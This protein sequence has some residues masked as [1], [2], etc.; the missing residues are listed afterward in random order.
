MREH[1]RK[2]SAVSILLGMD[3][4]GSSESIVRDWT[5]WLLGKAFGRWLVGIVGLAIMATGIGVGVAGFRAEFKDQ[6]AL[7]PKP[8]LLVTAL[9]IAG[10]LARSL[11]TTTIGLFL[12][13]A[14]I[15]ASARE[16]KGFAGAL[17]VIQQQPYGS[18]IFAITAIGLLAF[19]AFG[20]AEAVSRRISTANV[21]AI[22]PAWLRI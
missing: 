18:T 3:S 13:F 9:G 6:L 21:R 12:V 20:I 7:D 19:G 8:R 11:V 2:T 16:A 1:A 17:G 22:Q 14:A 5:A 4:G 10:F 15:D